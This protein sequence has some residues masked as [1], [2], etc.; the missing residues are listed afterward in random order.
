[1]TKKKFDLNLHAHRLLLGEPFFAAISRRIDKQATDAIPTAGV[2]IEDDGF[3]TLLYN[4]EYFGNLHEEEIADVLKHEFYHIIFEHISTRLPGDVKNDTVSMTWNIAT[5]LAINSHLRHLPEG[6]MIPGEDGFEDLPPGLTAEAY[7]KELKKREKE[8]RQGKSKEGRK[9]LSEMDEFDSH[10]GWG[11]NPEKSS[12]SRE[13]FRQMLEDAA[14]EAGSSG[15]WG[16]MPDSIKKMILSKVNS[17]VDWKKLLRY[18]IKTS[19]KADKSTTIKR[20]NKRYPFLHPGRKSNRQAKIAISIDQSGSVSDGMLSAFFAELNKLAELA[21]FTVVPF[22]TQVEE[23]HVYE[24]KKGQKMEHKRV[25][26]GGTDFNAPTEYVNSR[27]F[28]GHIVLTDMCAPKPKASKC[29]RMWMTTEYHRK[30]LYFQTN[31]RI[32]VIKDV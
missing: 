7:Y 23:Q 14:A 3:Y 28:D 18:F 6:A 4:P 5:D 9:K 20:I 11:E 15:S 27:D 25:M 21:T 19:Q 13:R 1:M 8:E 17:G 2:R 31:E 32:A 22:D 16:S 24:W 26:T 30:N 12:L 10:D 29:Q